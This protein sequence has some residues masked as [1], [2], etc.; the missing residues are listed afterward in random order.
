[1]EDAENVKP[2]PT[3]S[4]S[5]K[6]I[7]DGATV[8]IIRRNNAYFA[9][10]QI[11]RGIT[12]CASL[13]TTALSAKVSNGNISEAI[14]QMTMGCVGN[15]LTPGI[16]FSSISQFGTAKIRINIE[17]EKPLMCAFFIDSS[18]DVFT[19]LFSK[20]NQSKDGSFYMLQYNNHSNTT[21]LIA[22]QLP[23]VA[24]ISLQT[25]KDVLKFCHEFK[26]D[27]LSVCPIQILFARI[28]AASF[29]GNKINISDGLMNEQMLMLLGTVPSLI[30]F[31]LNKNIN[32]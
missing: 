31:R 14:K 12:S 4:T 17:Y 30:G 19:N 20:Q 1:M 15:S 5:L 22:V 29:N 13:G 32:R 6:N 28:V 27:L 25:Q 2:Y 9:L 21:S 10:F 18:K 11:N 16:E 26:S 8:S 3:C 7:V 23:H 24:N